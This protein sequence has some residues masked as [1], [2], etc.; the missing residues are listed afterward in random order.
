MA[1][2][3]G[4]T[5]ACVAASLDDFIATSTGDVGWLEAGGPDELDLFVMPVLLGQ[6]PAPFPDAR[7]RAGLHL[8]HT[9]TRRTGIVRPCYT[10]RP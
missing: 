8:M 10:L 6:G 5:I 4:S 1:G 9:A 2:L 7:A 3:T